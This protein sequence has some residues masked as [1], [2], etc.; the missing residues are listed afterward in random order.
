MFS[1]QHSDGQSYNADVPGVVVNHSPAS[2]EKFIGSPSIVILPDGS[3][4]AS[5]DFF[6]PRGARDRWNQ[7]L[8]FGSTDQGLT[9][10]HFAT[11]DH[12]FWSTLFYH[13]GALYMIGTY[14]QMGSTCIRKSVDGGSTWTEPVDGETGLLLEGRY[15]CAPVPVVRHNGRLWRAMEYVPK[16]RDFEAFM[17]S[18][19]E[20]ADL[21]NVD[22]W[23]FSNS[24]PFNGKWYNGEMKDWLEGNA[25]V[26]PDGEMVNI[27]RCG[28]YDDTDNISAMVHISEDGRTANFN[29]ESGFIS[30]PG[31]KGKKFT[32]RYDPVSGKYWSLVNWVQPKDKTVGKRNTA[33]LIS[34]LDLFSWTIER[35]V[36]HHPD[37]Y[38]HGFQ[39]ID[40]V[41]DG[42]DIIAVSRTAYDDGLGGAATNHDSNY[43]TFHRIKNFRRNFNFDPP[44]N[45]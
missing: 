41:F 32:I 11:I 9:W 2:T 33:S 31:G 1:T 20:D 19:P 40:W 24:I 36:L 38:H 14:G 7:T 15:H 17:M 21:L 28:F 43:M 30:L 16:D 29:P 35:I 8:V 42:K 22:N 5:H 6:G 27:L 12:Q 10:R 26:T 37:P 3:Y 23:V 4:V 25:L 39:Y 45:E 18:V 34:S 13:Q 44:W